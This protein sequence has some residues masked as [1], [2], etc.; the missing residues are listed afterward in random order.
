[1]FLFTQVKMLFPEEGLVYDYQLQDGGVSNSN[2]DGDDDDDEGKG[3]E[4]SQPIVI[5]PWR[6]VHH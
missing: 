3:V 5:V 4:V 6:R 1:M 2:N